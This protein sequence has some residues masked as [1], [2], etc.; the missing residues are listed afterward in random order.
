MS[1]YTKIVLLGLLA[2]L[3]SAA[4]H[5][6]QGNTAIVVGIVADQSAAPV[7]GAAVTLTHLDTNAVVEAVTDERGQ[8]RT[9]PLRIGRYEVSIALPGFKR[10]TPRDVVLCIG[11]VRTV[12]ATLALGEISEQSRSSRPCRC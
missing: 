5:A 8:Y 6:Q 1:E 9:P 12:N 10:F 3:T 7:P 2:V 11:D 4:A